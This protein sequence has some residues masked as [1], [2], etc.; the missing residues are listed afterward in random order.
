MARAI[1]GGG[2]PTCTLS[3]CAA[4]SQF[5]IFHVSIQPSSH[6][7]RSDFPSPVGGDSYFHRGTFPIFVGGLSTRLH[8]P[9]NVPVISSTRHPT[10]QR[11]RRFCAR[12]CRRVDAHCPPR[13]PLHDH[14]VT[15]FVRHSRY[16]SAGV[17]PPSS[18]L[19][20]HAPDHHPL[21][22]FGPPY[23][24]KSLQVAASPCCIM[25]ARWFEASPYRAA[26]EGPPSSFV[27]LRA[28]W[29]SREPIRCAR[30][31]TSRR[32]LRDPCTVAWIRTPPR[33]S[34]ALV[35]FFPLNI[36]LSSRSTKS[37]RETI[38]QHNFTQGSISGL[39]PFA[40]NLR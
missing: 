36:D 3:V 4:G 22:G 27:Q 5:P 30:G 19:L 34:G 16:R 18:L 40:V 15:A 7:G 17:A 31:A 24:A 26:P 25:A 1:L 6:P 33:F 39:Q 37:A 9:S 10:P 20:A 28:V 14:G 23:S 11:V 38:L 35:R 21:V 12:T 29:G 32:Y 13:A 8:A 2:F